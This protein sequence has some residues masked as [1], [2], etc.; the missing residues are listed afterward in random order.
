MS[1]GVSLMCAMLH[2]RANQADDPNRRE[3]QQQHAAVHMVVHLETTGDKLV[4]LT[5]VPPVTLISALPC[6]IGYKAWRQPQAGGKEAIE[7]R[8]LIIW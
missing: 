4:S 5:L 7:V 6:T 2:S 1:G 8:T 3:S